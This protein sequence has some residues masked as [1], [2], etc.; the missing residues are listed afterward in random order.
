MDVLYNIYLDNKPIKDYYLFEF[1]SFIGDHPLIVSRRTKQNTIF[2]V[3]FMTID[4][5]I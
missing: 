4:F 3:I 5:G 2:I 1:L